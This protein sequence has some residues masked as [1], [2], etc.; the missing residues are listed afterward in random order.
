[1]TGQIFLYLICL[2]KIKFIYFWEQVS[3]PQSTGQKYE[4]LVL[5]SYIGYVNI[6]NMVPLFGENCLLLVGKVNYDGRYM[7]HI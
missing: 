4:I 1:M 6:W 3:E 2:E 7:D 5:L